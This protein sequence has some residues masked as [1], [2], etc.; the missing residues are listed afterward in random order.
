MLSLFKLR[1][2]EPDMVR[3]FR[4]PC[5]PLFPAFALAGAIVCMA[6]MIYYNPLIFGV[7]AV[8]LAAGYGFFLATGSKRLEH[9]ATV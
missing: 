7:F 2:A 3:P 9:A 6:T 5:Y 1:R 8:F 4:A